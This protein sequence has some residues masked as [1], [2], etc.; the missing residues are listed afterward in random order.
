MS[1]GPPHRSHRVDPR[2]IAIHPIPD[3]TDPSATVEVHFLMNGGLRTNLKLFVHQKEDET[4]E[5]PVFGFLVVKRWKA[6]EGG[7][8]RVERMVFDLGVRADPQ[9]YTPAVTDYI[10]KHFAPL[11]RTDALASLRLGHLSPSDIDHIIISHPHFDHIGDPLAFPATT[12]FTI[13]DLTHLGAGYPEDPKG[14]VS[15]EMIRDRS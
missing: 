2:T 12:K 5:M 11:P 4:F 1:S 14:K 13:G 15:S 9:N 10:F 3:A 6:K 8:E 7:K